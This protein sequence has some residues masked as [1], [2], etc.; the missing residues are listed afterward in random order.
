[1]S[2]L[3]I[4]SIITGALACCELGIRFLGNLRGCLIMTA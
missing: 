1:M 4:I 3:V 2:C